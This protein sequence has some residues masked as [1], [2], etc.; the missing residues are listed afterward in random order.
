MMRIVLYKAFTL[1]EMMVVVAIILIILG[2]ALPAAQTMW[3]QTHVQNA[4]HRV[5][6]LLQVARSRSLDCNRTYGIFFYIDP[7]DNHEIAVF[8]YEL[9]YPIAPD[10][11]YPDVSGRLTVDLS[12][13]YSFPMKNFVRVAPLSVLEW[14]DIDILNDDYRAGKQRNFFAIIFQKGRRASTRPFMLYDEDAN[15]DDFGDTLGLPVGDTTGKHEGSLRDIVIDENG[16]RLIIPLD[17]GFFTYDENIFKEIRP[18]IYLI[19]YM[20]YYLARQGRTVELSP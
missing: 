16:E 8:V 3:N 11:T 6:N 10:E 7:S 20:P 4:H 19:P 9:G 18:D 2:L 14:E 15:N 17:W 5:A 13:K 12:G 1:V